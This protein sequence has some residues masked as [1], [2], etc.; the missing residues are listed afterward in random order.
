[1]VLGSDGHHLY[2]DGELAASGIHTHS[3][4]EQEGLNVGFSAAATTPFLAG[5]IDEVKVLSRALDAST[6]RGLFQSW[7]AFA[8]ADPGAISSTWSYTIPEGLEGMYQI[9]LTARDVLG[10]RNDD[11]ATWRHWRGAIDTLAPRVAITV[12]Y[13]GAGST[14]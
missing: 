5:S 14:A 4:F 7:I 10:N 6:V 9:D 3:S 1:Q 11:P 8:P 13:S 2:L 12:T